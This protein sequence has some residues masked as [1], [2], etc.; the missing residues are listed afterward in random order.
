MISGPG[1]DDPKGMVDYFMQMRDILV[2]FDETCPVCRA[3]VENI[4]KLDTLELVTCLPCSGVTQSDIPGCPTRKRLERAIHVRTATGDWYSG[5]DAIAVLSKA[6]PKLRWL[7][8]FLLLPGISRIA[9]PVYRFIACHRMRLS[10]I[11][12]LEG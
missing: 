12:R 5:S 11:M 2:I 3:G 8:R 1:G 7:G 4:R 9:R 10:R 6:L